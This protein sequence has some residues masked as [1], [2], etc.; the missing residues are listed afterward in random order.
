MPGY[1]TIYRQLLED[2]KGHS[3]VAVSG[4]AFKKVSGASDGPVGSEGATDVREQPFLCLNCGGWSQG[5]TVKLGKL[6]QK[7]TKKGAEVLSNFRRGLGPNP[8][9]RE[10][11]DTSLPVSR[12]VATMASASSTS[13]VSTVPQSFS[14]DQEA[15]Q[16]ERMMAALLAR[17]KAKEA[18]N[19]IAMA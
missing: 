12:L 18:A 19:S 17:I 13:S 11:I 16:H 8:R 2:P 10:L 15:P 7:P 4:Q 6:C 3:L 14:S 5:R 9:M 1:S